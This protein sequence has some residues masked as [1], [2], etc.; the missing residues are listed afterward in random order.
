MRYYERAVAHGSVTA[1]NN[2]AWLLATASEPALRDG[3]RAVTLIRPIALYSGAWQYLDTL[4]AAW[5][6]AG[7][8]Q[9]AADTVQRA[10][11]LADREGGELAG[12]VLEMAERLSGYREGRAYVEPAP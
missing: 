4:A 10:I 11:G 9:Q 6:A 1:R 3:N 5:A 8:Y 7:D 2:L 12:D